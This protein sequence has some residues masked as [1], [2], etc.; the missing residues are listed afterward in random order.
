M[1]GILDK[2]T[3]IIDSIVTTEGKRQISS[4][5]LRVEFASIT[6]GATYYEG[7]PVSGSADATQRIY[8]EADSRS[9]DS[10]V[11]ETDDSGNLLGFDVSPDISI[12]GNDIFQKAS[13]GSNLTEFLYVTG[14]DAF[15]SLSN[16]ILSSSIDHFKQLYLVGTK[17][18]E[19]NMFTQQFDVSNL[20]LT[21]TR[22]DYIISNELPFRSG[23]HTATVN[24]NTIEPLFLD[25]R[26]SHIPNFK[27]LPPMVIEPADSDSFNI[28]DFNRSAYPSGDFLGQYESLKSLE[29][30]SYGELMRELD[31]IENYDQGI[32]ID[33]LM[34][35]NS[36]YIEAAFKSTWSAS[37]TAYDQDTSLIARVPE[38]ERE[39]VYFT[40]TSSE[41]NI[42]MQMFEVDPNSSNFL[43]L[44][45]I[46]FGEIVVDDDSNPN[47]H[48]FFIGKVFIDDFGIP[49][50][51]NLFTI[52]MD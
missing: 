52:I 18:K 43:K 22:A 42:V 40:S 45:I 14:S 24:I 33:K 23:T 5:R 26:L 48:I 4:G 20:N 17:D 12:V 36:A 1:A 44:D 19:F 7:D 6:D 47:K 8:F 30:F 16:S 51:V 46:D 31:G 35:T 38:V 27:F 10:I 3:R 13:T 39:H 49:T 34:T 25:K 21:H 41:N 11:F 29:E 32:S 9:Q 50:F 37:E 2:K 15:A 28:E